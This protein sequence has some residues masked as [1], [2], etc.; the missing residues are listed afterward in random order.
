[1]SNNYGFQNEYDF[2]LAFNNKKVKELNPLLQDVVYSIF[3]NIREDDLI[4]SW[5]NH[6]DQ[7]TDI[8]LKIGNAMKGISIKMGSRN[9][10]H[11]ESIDEFVNFLQAHNI[12]KYIIDEYLKFHYA[13]GTL[14]NNGKY[15]LSS[16]DYKKQNQKKIDEINKY[17]NNNEII[18]DAFNRF[19][20][21]GNNSRYSIDGLIYGTPEDFLWITKGDIIDILSKQNNLYCSSPHFSSL[22]CQPMNRCLNYNKKYEKC[23]EYI[24]IKWYSL[25]DDILKQMNDTYIKICEC[26]E[27]L[28]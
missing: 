20:L 18:F 11:V 3:Y 14:N 27:L 4:K 7:K 17:F 26:S 8:F 21:K 5:R 19:V 10:V 13:D 23:R 15:R 2:V 16:E 6:Y 9:S 22:V 12:P 28:S 1:M 24:Q 25:F